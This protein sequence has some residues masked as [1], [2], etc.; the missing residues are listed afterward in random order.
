MSMYK[1][2]MLVLCSACCLVGGCSS[3]EILIESGET[4][5]GGTEASETAEE[6]SED[7]IYVYVCGQVASPGVYAVK[8]GDRWFHALE[9]AGGA[10]AGADLGGVNLAAVLAD[11]D[12]VYIP[13]EGE[14]GTSSEGEAGDSRVDINR[15][16]KEQLMTL[17]GIG[18]AKA[19]AIIAYREKEGLFESPEGLMNVPG[20]KAGVYDQIKDLIRID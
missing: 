19:E 10:S 11:G 2:W 3:E 6:S 12:K 7:L 18:E 8:P 4:S 1:I 13:A 5:Q 20:I 9:L 16:E 14:A 15:A 17:P